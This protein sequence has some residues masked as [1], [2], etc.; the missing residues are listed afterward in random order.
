MLIEFNVANYRSF[1]RGATLCMKAAP[2]DTLEESN[3]ISSGK[4]RLLQ[5]IVVYGANASGK[6]NLV[7]AFHFMKEMVLNSSKETQAHEKIDVAPYLLSTENKDQPSRVE[8]EFLINKVQYR[9]GFEVDQYQVHSEWFFSRETAKEA[10]LFT[11]EKGKINVNENRFKEG[12]GLEDRTRENALF[13][14][15]CAQFNGEIAT[16]V[17]AWFQD[18]QILHGSSF[19]RLYSST[20][21][22]IKSSK[23][24]NQVLNIAQIADPG[25][26]GFDLT[27]KKIT[28][29]D[30]PLD[31]PEE[32]KR[33]ILK[34]SA[35]LVDLKTKHQLVDSS[36]NPVGLITMDFDET[37]SDGTQ[38]I[39][40]L[41]GPLL[42]ILE[43]GKILVVDELDARLHPLLTR[44][45][46]SLFN[47]PANKTNAQLVFTTHDT[48]L[49]TSDLFR[50]DQV[51]FT[52]KDQF[53]GSDL[54]SLSEIKG[55]RKEAAFERDYIMG[56]YGAVP[57]ISD[58]NWLLGEV[59]DD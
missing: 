41:S 17:L 31:M 48:T 13:L 44:M 39:T 57:F 16:F 19:P 40:S 30:L 18:L 45:I 54:Y 58:L 42:D 5:S 25:I 21:N 20:I 32:I 43:T 46:V 47:S 9:Y 38:K 53:G 34:D 51:W 11:R 52:E 2:D 10:K 24:E 55:V 33:V 12:K 27:E 35:T 6:S 22:K 8:I 37:A 36:N 7:R 23:L 14:S 28:V 56:K 29:D 15:V 1:R 49:L 3:V 59:T 26:L 4:N 50:R